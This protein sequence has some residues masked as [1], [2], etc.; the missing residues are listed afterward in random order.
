ML[1]RRFAAHR[2][3][4]LVQAE[5]RQALMHDVRPD[6]ALEVDPQPIFVVEAVMQVLAK[7]PELFPQRR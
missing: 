3:A 2:F 5:N 6:A 1:E 7:W 4:R